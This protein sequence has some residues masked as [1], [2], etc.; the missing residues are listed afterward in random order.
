MTNEYIGFEDMGGTPHSSFIEHDVITVQDATDTTQMR[1]T[2][3]SLSAGGSITF[4]DATVQTTAYTGGGGSFTG[5]LV[6]SPIV[7]DG[8]SG[9][10][11]SKG[12]FDT[13][14]GGNYGISLVC[15]IGYEF[16]WQAGWLTTTNQGSTSPRP[17]YID[18]LAGTTLRAWDSSTDLGTE[19]S[20]TGVTF[21]DAT[22][23]A[24][25]AATNNSQLNTNVTSQGGSFTVTAGDANTIIR[26]Q[27]SATISLDD[28]S[29]NPFPYGAQV[30]FINES[31]STITFQTLNS[32]QVFSADSLMSISKN[33]G[34]AVA[35]K[36]NSYQWSLSGN[37]A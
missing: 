18:S 20:H 5:G 30:V 31:N 3:I 25:A 16:N 26:V 32:A 22:T 4:G 2:G 1:S 14:R 24:T 7:F 8:T 35:I 13:S 10:Y 23:Q 33:Y 21:S 6:T 17:L 29:N 34:T 27:G 36:L 15:S 28:D 37:L 12:N 9:Q 19:I 11:I